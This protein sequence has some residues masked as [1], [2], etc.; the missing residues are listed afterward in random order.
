MKKPFLLPAIAL[1]CGAVGAL[2]RQWHLLS[3]YEFG[4]GLPIHRAPATFALIAFGVLVTAGILLI[5]RQ[6]RPA[7]PLPQG[8]GYFQSRGAGTLLL[9]AA[10]G[11]LT[12]AAG[13]LYLLGVYSA[14]KVY[15]P[16]PGEAPFLLLNALAIVLGFL[17]LLA[18]AGMLLKAFTAF[19]G[20]TPAKQS[21]ALLLPAYACCIWLMVSYQGWASDPIISDY[22]FTMFAIMASMIAYYYLAAFSFASPRPVIFSTLAAL[23]I[24]FSCIAILPSTALPDKLMLIAQICYWFAMLYALNRNLQDPSC[25]P[26]AAADEESVPVIMPKEE[27]P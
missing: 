27:T 25:V 19:Q 22:V 6:S 14:H 9:T 1:L 24:F 18:G 8:S 20:K 5:A 21:L 3:A 11:I 26:P 23:G 4:T 15:L 13:A 12:A 7:A 2:L 10:A 16:K 17:C